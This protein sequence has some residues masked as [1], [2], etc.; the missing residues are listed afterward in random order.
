MLQCG[1]GLFRVGWGRK[2]GVGNQDLSTM[3]GVTTDYAERLHEEG[4]MNIQNL[5]FID[6]EITRKRTMFNMNML[7]EWKEE[8]NLR[9]LTGD[10]LSKSSQR[11]KVGLKRMVREQICMMC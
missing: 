3:R 9:L 11:F 10:I 6:V 4:I 2:S 8:V 1:Q 5:A 7:F